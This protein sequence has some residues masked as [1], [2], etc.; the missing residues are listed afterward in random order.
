MVWYVA[1]VA[2][3]DVGQYRAQDRKT[4][5]TK[6]EKSCKSSVGTARLEGFRTNLGKLGV[7]AS[8]L[9]RNVDDK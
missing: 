5:K 3:C 1:Q 9:A 8:N 7:S 6:C 4:S 2:G